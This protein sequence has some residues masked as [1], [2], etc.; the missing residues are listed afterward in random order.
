MVCGRLGLTPAGEVADI[1]LDRVTQYQESDLCLSDPACRRVRAHVQD[2][3]QKMIFQRKDSV[4]TA[5][6]ARTFKR[7]T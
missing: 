1:P 6:S 2:Q 4:L 5:D 7:R 3:R